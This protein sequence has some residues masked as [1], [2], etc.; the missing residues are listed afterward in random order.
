LRTR[1]AVGQLGTASVIEN[2]CSFET[3][4]VV[5]FIVIIVGIIVEVSGQNFLRRHRL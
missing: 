3:H 5:D 4:H 1:E 2:D